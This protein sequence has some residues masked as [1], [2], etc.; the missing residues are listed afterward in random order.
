MFK[1]KYAP[2][3]VLEV[4]EVLTLKTVSAV[5]SSMMQG[6]AADKEL[7][8]LL[9]DDVNASQQAV[10]ELKEILEDAGQEAL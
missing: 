7:K 8:Q 6:L 4:H 3:E 10:D 2:H 9:E 5:K 1:K